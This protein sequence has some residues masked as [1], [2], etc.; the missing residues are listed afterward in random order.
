MQVPHLERTL[1]L[2]FALVNVLDIE[3]IL[4]LL[5]HVSQNFITTI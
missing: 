2:L 3:H 5:Q 1:G 4:M